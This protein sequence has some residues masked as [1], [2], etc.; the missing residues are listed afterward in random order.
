[1][2]PDPRAER[3]QGARVLLVGNWPPPPGGVSIHVRSLRDAARKAGAHVTVL[4]IGEGQHQGD[5]VF[6]GGSEPQFLARLTAM[7]RSNDLVHLHTSGANP[8]SWL[9]TGMVGLT[10]RTAGCTAVVTFHSGHGPPKRANWNLVAL[11]RF[12]TFPA[13]S[14]LRK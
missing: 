5:G 13:T 2:P 7:V 6:P 9:L 1:M 10:A 8:K 3:L 12:S 4:D 14:I 11:L